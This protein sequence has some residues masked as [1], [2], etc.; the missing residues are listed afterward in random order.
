M[1]ERTVWGIWIVWIVFALGLLT[2][3]VVH[4]FFL[5]SRREG[6]AGVCALSVPEAANTL[7][8]RN[9]QTARPP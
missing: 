3:R 1:T 5:Y 2:R 7:D 4:G 9:P 6:C 8:R